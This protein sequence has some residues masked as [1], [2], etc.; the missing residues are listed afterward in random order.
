MA[1]G[2]IL[3]GFSRIISLLW[4]IL[5]ICNASDPWNLTIWCSRTPHPNVCQ[6]HVQRI[7]PNRGSLEDFQQAT[8]IFAIQKAI[9][10]TK[11]VSENVH[12]LKTEMAKPK[13]KSCGNHFD[14]AFRDL[15]IAIGANSNDGRRH[16]LSMALASVANCNK[17]SVSGRFKENR[18][19]VISSHLYKLIENAIAVNNTSAPSIIVRKL[20]L[21]QKRKGGHWKRPKHLKRNL[22]RQAKSPNKCPLGGRPY[23]TTPPVKPR[24]EVVVAQDG[25]GDFRTIDEALD[26]ARR[27]AN[28]RFLIHLKEGTYHEYVD[29]PSDLKD[30]TVIGDGIGKT[31][32]TGNKHAGLE[33][34]DTFKS[35]T[36]AVKGSGFIAQGITFRNTAGR[37][38]GQAVA[39]RTHS[40][41][42]AFYKCSFEGYQDTLFL[43]PGRQFFRDC[44]IYGSMDMICGDS[45]AVFQNCNILLRKHNGS[46]VIITAQKRSQQDD[47]G[48][49][50][51]NSRVILTEE[52]KSLGG[53]ELFLGRPWGRFSRTV[54]MKTYLEEVCKQG[55]KEMDGDSDGD[56]VY[57]AEFGNTGPGAN[58]AGRIKWRGVRAIDQHEAS[59]FTVGRFLQG[60]TWLPA[61]GIPYDSDL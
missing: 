15:A 9:N 51:Q 59:G 8:V 24:N 17:E 20:S 58:T 30:I 5:T 23:P 10:L 48:F 13:W 42:S 46:D 35:A 4:P 37:N 44:D 16:S 47:S 41:H 2:S 32:I 29:I 61:T 40:D 1:M 55:W 38:A 45:T 56:L 11:I 57:Y 43:F 14:N 18:L 7:Y 12:N 53:V 36:F 19:T 6:S 22:R 25:S 60:N 54:F 26:V 21:E 39:V 33:G 3:Y 28:G 52:L 49:V 31:V 34:I 50:I 27:R